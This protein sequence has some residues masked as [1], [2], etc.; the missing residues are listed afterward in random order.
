MKIYVA[1]GQW[2]RNSNLWG[3][4]AFLWHKNQNVDTDGD[5]YSE[6]NLDWMEMCFHNRENEEE[7]VYVNLAQTE[8]IILEV[9]CDLDSICAR[10]AFYLARESQGKIALSLTAPF[11]NPN[12][13]IAIMGDFDLEAAFQ[14]VS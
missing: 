6:E 10:V 11:Q 2:S 9:D 4:V 8:P 14:R 12:A 5:L 7:R 13:L 1:E 3:V